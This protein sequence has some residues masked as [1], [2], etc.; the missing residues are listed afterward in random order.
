MFR[1]TSMDDA[2]KELLKGYAMS[3]KKE[4]ISRSG[5]GLRWSIVTN[6]EKGMSARLFA[7][8]ELVLLPLSFVT[9]VY[10]LVSAALSPFGVDVSAWMPG[11]FARWLL[12]VLVAA[13]IG[14]VTNWLAILML[15]R[16]YERHGWLFV[17]P[18]GLLPRNKAKMAHEIGQ[19]VGTELLPPESLV[20][21]LEREVRGYLSRPDVIS[22][23]R[24][25][26]KEM[27]NRHET[28]IVNLLV[29]QLERASGDILA[30]VLT[31]DRIRA[32]W[33]ETLAPKLNDPETRDFLAKKITEVIDANAPELARSI[34][35]KLKEYLI[36]KLS[37]RSLLA[38][39]PLSDIVE[40][41]M[42]FFA[43]TATVRKMISDWLLQPD[44]QEMFKDKL[45]LLGEK[46]NEW[47][48]SEQGRA[49]VEMFAAGLREKGRAF[50]SDYIHE[51]LPKLVSQAFAS[52]KLWDWV[53]NTALPSA[54]EKAL[55]YLSE[56]KEMIAEKLC[57]SKR[58]ED[59]INNQ[60]I[61]RFH[62]MLNDIA[63]QHLS[64][65]QV[66]G[67]I[68]GAVVGLIQIAR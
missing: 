17:W 6:S 18:Q 37:E 50:L 3:E 10:V 30:R 27:L 29:P 57:L 1:Y 45:L 31:A 67:Y 33:D 42:D 53:E 12:P 26:V 48:K 20:A 64:A 68:L 51:S 55:A 34:R 66:L 43:D 35:G 25:M 38:L 39:L 23:L 22:R 52:E 58:I 56:N 54:R 5:F 21:E 32:F 8:V 63:A 65:I 49:K 15:F 28:D 46:T 41:V 4:V 16:P 11:W 61:E 19:K 24:E 60:D 7:A 44:T 59:A 14:Y 9:F 36:A 2:N 40:K 13:A 47:L 62:R